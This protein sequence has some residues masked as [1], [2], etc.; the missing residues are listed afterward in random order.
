MGI[1][2][3]FKK[4]FSIYLFSSCINILG[5]LTLFN[6]LS[7]IISIICFNTKIVPD[8]TH[9]AFSNLFHLFKYLRLSVIK[10]HL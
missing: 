9:E 1:Q 7:S 6:G 2:V 5:I 8:S 3:N 10:G 4:F